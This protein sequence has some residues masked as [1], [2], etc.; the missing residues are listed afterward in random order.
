MKTK[1]RSKIRLKLFSDGKLVASATRHRKTQIRSILNSV[2]HQSAYVYVEYVKDYWND[3]FHKSDESLLK[4]LNDYTEKSLLD[5]V[6][7]NEAVK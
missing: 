3:S 6:L 5:F 7:Q 4:A 1:S 2:F